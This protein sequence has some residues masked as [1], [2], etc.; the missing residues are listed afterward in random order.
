MDAT[1]G[2]TAP[3]TLECPES[4]FRPD[5]LQDTKCSGHVEAVFVRALGQSYEWD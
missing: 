3:E 2:G 1:H 5:R 4:R